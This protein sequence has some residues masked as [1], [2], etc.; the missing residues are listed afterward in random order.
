VVGWCRRG[1]VAKSRL[2]GSIKPWRWWPSM[3]GVGVV[4]GNG[5]LEKLKI[6]RV[7]VLSE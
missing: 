3:V 2:N 6:G 7:R 1:A 5:D 4:M